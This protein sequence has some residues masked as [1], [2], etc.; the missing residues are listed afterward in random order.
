MKKLFLYLMITGSLIMGASSAVY[1]E[2]ASDYYSLHDY[3][4]VFPFYSESPC[5]S[6]S[7]CGTLLA[8]GRYFYQETRT[9]FRQQANVTDSRVLCASDTVCSPEPLKFSTSNDVRN[10]YQYFRFYVPPGATF[11]ALT[12]YV[13]RDALMAA[14][15]RFGSPPTWNMATPFS[16][17]PMT[18]TSWESIVAGTGVSGNQG[19]R[20]ELVN[21]GLPSS[22]AITETDYR[23][24]SYNYMGR[25]LYV[26]VLNYTSGQASSIIFQVTVNTA[27]YKKWYN[28]MTEKG[29]W[30]NFEAV[31]SVV[32][33]P[34]TP[35]TT[36]PT[37]GDT[38]STTPVTG[39]P[40]FG[41]IDY[42]GTSGST[43]TTSPSLLDLLNGTP[44]TTTPTT[45]T[46]TQTV[47]TNLTTFLTGSYLDELTG[48]VMVN[49]SASK[50]RITSGLYYTGLPYGHV[51]CYAAYVE[52]GELYMAQ[53]QSNGSIDFLKYI[54]GD[55]PYYDVTFLNGSTNWTCTAFNN[56][57]EIDTSTA[58]TFVYG[59]SPNDMCSFDLFVDHFK[60]AWFKVQQVAASTTTST[61]T[62]A[63]GIFGGLDM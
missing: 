3:P 58:K 50:M 2:S 36:T 47:S 45:T 57:G 27:E 63:G 62:G 30:A 28:F 10:H 51:R 53:R 48:P 22:L 40:I 35:T 15:G 29:Y 37:T 54:S 26:K 59:V 34:T 61:T 14:V 23:S 33:T 39:N 17:I 52:N 1:A 21:G 56:L 4:K 38:S 7:V 31:G 55:I 41:G 32:T 12:L 43:T 44:T 46:P 16:S 9:G 49:H 24:P 60:G 13:P 6:T 8:D 20:I 18:T 11:A 42:N 25:W 19:G 5:L